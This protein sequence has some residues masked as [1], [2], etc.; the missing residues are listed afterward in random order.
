MKWVRNYTFLGFM[1]VIHKPWP[2]GNDWH[3]ISYSD[4]GILISFELVEGKDTPTE[5]PRKLF[6]EKENCVFKI[7]P[8]KNAT[9]HR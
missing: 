9:R 6:R 8:H 3:T 5:L 4:S 7:V 1:F 2:F